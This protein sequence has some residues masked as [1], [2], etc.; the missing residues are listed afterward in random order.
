MGL[1]Q[2]LNDPRP[3]IPQSLHAILTAELSD[4]AGRQTLVAL[5]EDHGLDDLAA[6]FTVALK[7]EREHLGLVTT[8]FA[9]RQRRPGSRPRHSSCRAPRR[10]RA[11]RQRHDTGSLT[12]PPRTPRGRKTRGVR[13]SAIKEA[14]WRGESCQ[15]GHR[16]HGW[17]TISA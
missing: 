15:F 10:H 9:I 4:K 12:P 11:A 14:S 17:P 13:A 6:E 5:A 3:A 8:W 16:R 2:V 7:K 1:V